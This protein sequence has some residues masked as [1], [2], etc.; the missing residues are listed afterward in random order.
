MQ[1]HNYIGETG[2]SVL[3]FFKSGVLKGQNSMVAL[4]QYNSGHERLQLMMKV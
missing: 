3:R 1:F 2:Y 4:Q